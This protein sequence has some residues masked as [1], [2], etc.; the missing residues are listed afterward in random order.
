[1]E[2]TPPESWAGCAELVL[3]QVDD[4]RVEAPLLAVFQVAVDVVFA[5]LNDQRP[6]GVPDDE[7]GFAF[8]IDE[9]PTV[10]RCSQRE[11]RSRGR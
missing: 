2:P 5:E 4:D 6:S 1:M 3:D 9:E 10:V 7:E 11:H 8:L